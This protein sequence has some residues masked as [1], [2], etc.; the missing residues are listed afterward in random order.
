MNTACF[1]PFQAI[2]ALENYRNKSTGQLS[3]ITVFLMFAGCL[4]RIFTSVQETGDRL[5]IATFCV[6]SMMNGLIFGQILIYWHKSR[7]RNCSGTFLLEISDV[8]IWIIVENVHWN[9][10]SPAW[11]EL[12]I[13]WKCALSRQ[14]VT[15]LFQISLI[16][17]QC[18][19]LGVC[20]WINV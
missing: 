10:H 11:Q 4:V 1:G 15:L 17:F 9:K 3:T 6:A 2:Q 13:L 8:D 7:E 19:V 20:I 16:Y 12:G 18:D 14:T 5:V